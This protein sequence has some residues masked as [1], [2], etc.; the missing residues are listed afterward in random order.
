MTS[1]NMAITQ[2]NIETAADETESVS[3]ET[4]T[5]QTEETAETYE[6]VETSAIGTRM[7][8]AHISDYHAYPEDLIDYIG[9]RFYDWADEMKSTTDSDKTDDCPYS[10]YNIIE[11]LKYFDVPEEYFNEL[12]Y[13]KLYYDY[14]CTAETRRRFGS[15]SR[16]TENILRGT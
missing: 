14:L 15:S 1:C 4:E 10:H 11:C 3:E 2:E 5:E 13:A 8:H 12:Y 9:D 7:C 16:T 6:T